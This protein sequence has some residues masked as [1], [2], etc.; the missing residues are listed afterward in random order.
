MAASD[1]LLDMHACMR[2]FPLYLP[3]G[4]S[5]SYSPITYSIISCPILSWLLSLFHFL[6]F[7]PIQ[8]I[9]NLLLVPAGSSRPLVSS[10][11]IALCCIAPGFSRFSLA[12]VACYSYLLLTCPVAVVSALP[13]LSILSILSI[14]SCLL[15]VCLIV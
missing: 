6:C 1:R 10:A 15:P 7:H 4:C 12:A 5:H 11:S 9:P 13:S 2:A 8:S 3:L 14:L